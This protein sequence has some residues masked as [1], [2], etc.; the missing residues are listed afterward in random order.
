MDIFSSEKRSKVMSKI[1]CKDTAPELKLRRAIWANGL[2][3]RLQ[4]RIGRFRPDI[5]FVKARLVIFVDG[6]FWHHCPKHGVMPKGNRKFWEDKLGK[7]VRRDI[8]T[9]RSLQ[10]NGW[11]VIRFWEHDVNESIDDC[12][13]LV[14]DYIKHF[15]KEKK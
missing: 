9:Q 10:E 11:H 7:N 15:R 2:R 6:C 8:E 1:R 3:Y 12:V 5:V 13:A 14:T 4:Y